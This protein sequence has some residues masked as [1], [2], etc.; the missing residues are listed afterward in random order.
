MKKKLIITGLIAGYFF[1]GGIF[2][3]MAQEKMSL[4]SCLETGLN[5]NFDVR[6]TKN[7]QQIASNN[8]TPG[9]AGMLPSLDLKTGITGVFGDET[10][11]PPA[12][13][14]LVNKGMYDSGLSAGVQ[15]NWTI[16]DGFSMF[17]G[18]QKLKELQSQGELKTKL[19]IENFISELT[20]EYYNFI[21]QQIRYKNLKY[22]VKLS[23]ERLRIVD[24]RYQIGSM[25][26]MDLQQAKVDFNAD[27]SKLFRQKEILFAS[28]IR[29]NQLMAEKQ[30]EKRF[31]P[32]D[33]A[34]VFNSLLDKKE[35]MDKM[36][37]NNVF[38]LMAKKEMNLCVLELKSAQSKNLP[39]VKL[40]AGYGYSLNRY[41]AATYPQQENMGLNYGL[42][43]GYNLF[44]GFNRRREQQ[45]ARISIENKELEYQQLELSLKSDF[46]NIWMAYQNNRELTTLEHQNL[47]NARLNYEIAMER[48]RLGDLSGIELREAQNSLLEAEDRLVQAQYNTKMCEISLLQL[49]GGISEYIK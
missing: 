38:L 19:T 20:A 11:T 12:G 4:K 29:I 10:L 39:Y 21:H 22:A 47:G 14:T 15:L 17:T 25:S 49:S 35:L 48:Y 18:Y 42:T 16:F 13:A 36:Q 44:D 27:S 6:I 8:L 41:E 46:A 5:Q 3:L 26:G 7:E 37:Q 30:T 2:S 24:S 32:L 31:I 40:N 45:N 23:A 9:N 33:T 43:L 34:I 28:R 1:T